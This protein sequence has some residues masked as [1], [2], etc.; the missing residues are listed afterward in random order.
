MKTQKVSF[1]DWAAWWLSAWSND[2]DDEEDDDDD[3]DGEK[4]KKT[5]KGDDDDGDDVNAPITPQC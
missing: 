5:Q 3:N 2:V 1:D 4:E